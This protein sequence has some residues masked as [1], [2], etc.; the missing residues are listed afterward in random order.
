MDPRLKFPNLRNKRK[1]ENC[2]ILVDVDKTEKSLEV[3]TS[4]TSLPEASIMDTNMEQNPK[5]ETKWQ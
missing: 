1:S 2:V 3:E 5:S 4:A